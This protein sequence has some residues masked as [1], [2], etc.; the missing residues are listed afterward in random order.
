[1]LK[2]PQTDQLNQLPHT[3][4]NLRVFQGKIAGYIFLDGKPGKQAGLL[5]NKTLLYARP[6]NGPPVQQ[7][8]A[9]IGIVQS[10]D[11]LEQGALAA[12]A[13]PDYCDKLTFTNV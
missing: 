1:M 10:S 3:E 11:D 8:A 4:A 2:T 9:F 6:L 12:A 5:K 7:N 13:G